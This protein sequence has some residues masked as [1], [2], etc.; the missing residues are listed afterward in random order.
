MIA[1]LV[2]FDNPKL[3]EDPQRLR[4][5]MHSRATVY[6][7][8]PGLLYKFWLDE[9]NSSQFGAML[10][11]ENR[12]AL[13]TYQAGQTNQSLAEFWGVEPM[14]REFSV[15]QVLAVDGSVTVPTSGGAEL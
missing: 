4:E 3:S 9:P 13:E 6:G 15:N 10:V 1:T 12:E 8:I 11:W 7:S 5:L 2:L 14:V